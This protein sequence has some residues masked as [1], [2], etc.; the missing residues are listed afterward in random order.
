MGPCPNTSLFQS[1]YLD[2]LC[3]LHG[4]HTVHDTL[5]VTQLQALL[6]QIHRG[7]DSIVENS[8]YCARYSGPRRMMTGQ[9]NA[10]AILHTN[11]RNH[12]SMSSSAITIMVIH[13]AVNPDSGVTPPGKH[14]HLSLSQESNSRSSSYKMQIS[15]SEYEQQLKLVEGIK[16]AGISYRKNENR[17]LDTRYQLPYILR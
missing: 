8:C 12:G 15:G 14:Q 17:V 16:Q 11:R 13:S 9:A 2:A 4:Q 5:V 10:Q 1:L 6:H 7:H 3:P